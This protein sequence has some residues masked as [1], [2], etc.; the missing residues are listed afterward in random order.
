MA[1][2]NRLAHYDAPVTLSV[3]LAQAT[4]VVMLG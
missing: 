4:V 1:A 3:A 2:N